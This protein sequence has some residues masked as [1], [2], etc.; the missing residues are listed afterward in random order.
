MTWV[1]GTKGVA[2][3]SRYFQ[4][5]AVHGTM[6]IPNPP[7]ALNRS[8]SMPVQPERCTRVLGYVATVLCSFADNAWQLCLLGC[9]GTRYTWCYSCNPC[10]GSTHRHAPLHVQDSCHLLLLSEANGTVCGTGAAGQHVH[11]AHTTVP[12]MYRWTGPMCT[13]CLH[14]SNQPFNSASPTPPPVAA[15]NYAPECCIGWLLLQEVVHMWGNSCTCRVPCGSSSRVPHAP[16]PPHHL[17]IKSR[18]HFARTHLIMLVLPAAQCLLLLRFEPAPA[19]APTKSSLSASDQR[20]SKA[21]EPLHL[22]C[23]RLLTRSRKF[24]PHILQAASE[25]LNYVNGHCLSQFTKL[26]LAAVCSQSHGPG[27]DTYILMGHISSIAAESRHTEMQGPDC[28]CSYTH[29]STPYNTHP[30][31]RAWLISPIDTCYTLGPYQHPPPLP[32]PNTITFTR[33]LRHILVHIII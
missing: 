3:C 12:C 14:S 24:K 9:S 33:P 8:N 6:C 19:S 28:G 32:P 17:H 18:T 27:Q 30:I 5:T 31:C 10:I 23:P 7:S 11:A 15:G 22:T 1:D 25:P 16:M 20:P 29:E 4:A 21:F 2:C 26:D 13:H